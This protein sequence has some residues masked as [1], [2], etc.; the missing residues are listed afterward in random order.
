MKKKNVINILFFIFLNNFIFL[1]LHSKIVN[2]IIAKVGN[3][4]ITSVDLQN[5]IITNLVLDKKNLSQENINSAKI[6]SVKN[7]TNRVIKNHEINK[8]QIKNFNKKDLQ[9]YI[10]TVAKNFNTD[11]NGLKE[12]FRQNNISFSKFVERYKIELLWNTLIFQIYRNQINLN[13]VE[14][15]NE[16]KKIKENKNDEELKQITKEITDKKKDD[17]LNLF[18]RSHFSS[19]ENSIYIDFK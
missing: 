16:I 14:I 1:D 7:L 19:L 6:Y 2:I 17:Q 10:E 8:Y 15:N 13:T 18:S 3:S 4:L 9:K 11:Q 5:E 12:I